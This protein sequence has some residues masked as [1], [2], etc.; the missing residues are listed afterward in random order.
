[1]ERALLFGLV[2]SCGSSVGLGRRNSGCR[3][4]TALWLS[5]GVRWASCSFEKGVTMLSWTRVCCC[6]GLLA[7]LLGFLPRSLGSSLNHFTIVL[8]MSWHFSSFLCESG[9]DGIPCISCL[10]L[11]FRLFILMK[12]YWHPQRIHANGACSLVWSGG[13]LC[14]TIAMLC[15]IL[16]LSGVRIVSW[17]L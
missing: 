8:H 1:M 14:A 5:K 11:L 3:S 9:W 6:I 16:I 10:S 17:L 13:E 12:A 4:W 2:E 15:T 7:H